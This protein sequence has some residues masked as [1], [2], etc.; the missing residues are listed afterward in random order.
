VG[1]TLG[2]HDQSRLQEY[3]EVVDLE[4]VDQEGGAMAAVTLC[5]G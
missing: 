5:I 3:F 4:A 2:G 1:D